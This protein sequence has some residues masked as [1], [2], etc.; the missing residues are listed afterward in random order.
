LGYVDS[1]N[2]Y[3]FLNRNPV[4]F[5]DPLGA[6]FI[7][8]EIW[9]STVDGRL[10]HYAKLRLF[11]NAGVQVGTT[12]EA[13]AEGQEKAGHSRALENG[14]T[15][16]G[17]YLTVGKVFE[18]VVPYEDLN[19]YTLSQLMEQSI[20]Y[21][22]ARERGNKE[23]GKEKAVSYGLGT[24]LMQP[25]YLEAGAGSRSDIII[26]GGGTWLLRDPRRDP[27]DLGPWQPDQRLTSTQGCLRVHNR[28]LLLM[29]NLIKGLLSASGNEGTNRDRQDGVIVVGDKKFLASLAGKEELV[30]LWAKAKVSARTGLDLQLLRRVLSGYG[31]AP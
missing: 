8:A 6:W 30:S 9:P 26:H 14:D 16:F 24:I 2:L 5:L 18:E 21:F 3:Q 27:F 11:S 29:I 10:R 4:N 15:P 17:V 7:V 13:L 12:L 22:T 28:D 20:R 23:K 19:K 25:L 1:P 31:S